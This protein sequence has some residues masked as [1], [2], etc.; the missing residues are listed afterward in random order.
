[1]G[2]TSP[3]FYFTLTLTLPVTTSSWSVA[4]SDGSGIASDG[5]R[6]ASGGKIGDATAVSVAERS[7]RRTSRTS[8]RGKRSRTFRTKGWESASRRISWSRW[9][10]AARPFPLPFWP[11]APLGPPAGSEGR[12]IDRQRELPA[13]EPPAEFGE[14]AFLL[15]HIAQKDVI[16]VGG[17]ILK[18]D[19]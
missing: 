12:G 4:S 9:F 13:E 8:A 14:F 3:L 15:L 16:L 11:L 10:F 5:G 17:V 1:M 19:P 7:R 6:S 2:T 18:A